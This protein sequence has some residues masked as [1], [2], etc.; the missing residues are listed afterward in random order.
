ML[1]IVQTQSK[2]AFLAPKKASSVLFSSGHLSMGTSTALQIT[3]Q[4]A[5]AAK[6]KKNLQ[7]WRALDPFTKGSRYGGACV[8]QE[9]RR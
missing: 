3:Q 8:S 6:F 9:G 7:N 5:H 4:L 2:R 1:D